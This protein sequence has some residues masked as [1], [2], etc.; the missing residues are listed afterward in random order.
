MDKPVRILLAENCNRSASPWTSDSLP[1]TA[2]RIPRLTSVLFA[3]GLMLWPA[4]CATTV[5][6]ASADLLTFLE[7]ANTTREEVLL[8]LGQPSG[9]F[10]QERIFTYR[11]GEDSEQGRYVVSA[12]AMM[13]WQNVHYSLVLVFDEA[14]TLKK[15]RLVTVH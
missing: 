14:G 12:K 8:R 4:G 13:P 6:G 2:A 5:P 15:Q 11:I 7:E 1:A 3:A 9:S 10:E